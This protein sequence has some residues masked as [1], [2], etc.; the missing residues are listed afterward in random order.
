MTIRLSYGL[1]LLLFTTSA[2]ADGS[3]ATLGSI[4][5]TKKVEIIGPKGMRKGSTGE[6]LNVGDTITTPP[7]VTLTIRT[8]DESILLVGQKS[9]VGITNSA[10]SKQAVELDTG[11]V[12]GIFGKVR[13]KINLPA[14]G[15]LRFVLKTK[16]AVLGVRGTDFVVSSDAQAVTSQINTLQG[17]VEVAKTEEN[18]SKGET[19]KVSSGE[20]V[21]STPQEISPPQ[22]FDQ[23]RFMENLKENQPGLDVAPVKPEPESEPSPTP[24]P[25]P[26]PTAKAAEPDIGSSL[27]SFQVFVEHMNFDSNGGCGNCGNNNNNNGP[28]NSNNSCSGN[29]GTAGSDGFGVTWNPSWSVF[30]NWFWIRGE[31]GLLHVSGNGNYNGSS[32]N[33]INVTA[34]LVGMNFEFLLFRRLIIGVGPEFQSW[35]GKGT[36]GGGNATLGWRFNRFLGFLDRVFVSVGPMGGPD[37]NQVDNSGTSPGSCTTGCTSSLKPSA[38]FRAGLGL[39]F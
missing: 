16:T 13:K 20:F 11:T 22:V 14:P 19:V 21:Q 12:R 30:G 4:D 39:K 9:K 7:N 1:L 31:F 24:S 35:F 18:L 33:S 8:P 29:C 37:I 5:G 27:A 2:Y 28:G 32:N 6:P 36:A 25:S 3:A 23:N 38:Q 15:K 26:T 34:G 10:L 17:T